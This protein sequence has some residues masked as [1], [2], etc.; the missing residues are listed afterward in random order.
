MNSQELKEKL[1]ISQ[2]VLRLSQGALTAAVRDFLNTYYEGQPLVIT[3][4]QPG[5]EGEP[6]GTIQLTGRSSF[7]NVPD[8]PVSARFSVDEQGEVHALLKYRLR[9]EAP[10]PAA[11]TFSRSFPKLPPVIDYDTE[12]PRGSALG[13]FRLSDNQ[14][15]FLDALDLFDTYFVV[16]TH[17]GKDPELGVPLEVGLNFVSRL[18]PQGM[19]GV[20]EHTLGEAPSLLLYG[21]IR[22]PKATDITLPL[23]PMQLPWDQ[24]TAPGIHLQAA[25]DAD[26]ELGGLRFNRAC[27]RVYSPPSLEWMAANPSFEPVHGYAGTLAIPSAG[28]E[29]Q[30]GARLQWNLPQALL[31]A[32]CKGITLGKMAHLLDLAGTGDLTAYLPEE[33]RKPI[34]ALGSLELMY[35][36]V[37]LGLSGLTPVLDTAYFTVGF[38]RLKWKVWGDHLEVE[39][40][41]CHFVIPSPLAASTTPTSQPAVSVTMFGTLEVEG[42][43]LAIRASNDRGF[44]VSAATK[45]KVSL[46]LDKL[47]AAYAPGVPTP[48]ALTINQLG[49]NV[50]LGKS[51]SMSA[52]LAGEPEPWTIPLGPEKLEIADVTLNFSYPTGGPLAGSFG[53]KITFAEGI[54]LRA[55]YGIP[56]NFAVEGHFPRVKLSNLIEKLC[57]QKVDLPGGFDLVLDDSAVLIQKQG[58]SYIFRLC[59]GVKDFGVFAFEVRKVSGGKWGY[60]AGMDLSGGRLSQLPGL[61]GLRVIEDAFTLQK[62]MLVVSS[63][64]DASF[65]FPTLAQFNRPQLATKNL[66]LPAQTSGVSPGLMLFAEWRLDTGD[67]QQNLLSKLLGLGITQSVTLAV[68]PD[69]MKSSRLYVSQRATI[70][71]HPFSCTF[72]VELQSG[73]PN[74]FLTG[75]LTCRIQGQPQTFD[76]TMAFAPGGAF[77]SG[78]MKGATAINCGPFKLSNLA[79]EVGV[80]WA[81]IPSLGVAATIDVKKFQSSVAVFFDSTDPS[82]SLVAGSLS[83][84]TLE[85]VVDSLVGGAAPSPLDEILG[86][87]AV[88][89]TREFSIPGDLADELDG[90]AFDKVSS[91][92]STAAKIQIPSSASQLLL[93]VNK[94]GSAWHL[95]DLTTMRHYQLEKRGDTIAV[96]IAPQ[97]YFAPQATSIGSLRYPQGFY[98]N[99][100]IAFLGFKAEAT[101]DISTSKGASIDAQMDRIA[102]GNEKLFCISAEQGPG[103][104]RIS[105]STFTQPDHPVKEFRPPHF[106]VNGSLVLLGIKRSVY[107]SLSSKG[108]VFDLQGP[109]VPGVNFNVQARLGGDGL[110]ASGEIKVGVGTLDLGKLGKVRLQTELK[111]KLELEISAKE[112]VIAAEASFEFTGQQVHIG[113]FKLDAKPDVLKELPEQLAR[114]AEKELTALFSDMGKWASAVQ[115]GLV[116]GVQDTAKVFEDVYG[117]GAKEAS[118]EVS[119]GAKKAGKEVSKGAKKAGK[120]L[121]KLF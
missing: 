100:A 101:I 14:R 75:S 56:G 109:L 112:I 87:I 27:F 77:F 43:P 51:Y 50:S 4:A 71:G 98:L 60:A 46:P 15:P 82:R 116:D 11:W 23:L 119:K 57:D 26:L 103:G 39:E 28:I 66:A 25:L 49:V 32:E 44:T 45:G 9:E 7:L 97:F 13:N 18:R 99:A 31:F 88:K 36:G 65:Q 67:R 52:I 2:G 20:L 79:L 33:L 94:K 53:G 104:P 120:K 8:L 63:F 58:D 24:P 55:R 22:L 17:A 95:T 38:P 78:T 74:L 84:L 61:S 92:F 3:D 110:D 89:G 29:L 107:A 72:G 118:K 80:N 111:G 106:Y 85:D 117:K 105:A 93:V 64:Q 21:T 91:A 83:D 62:L 113:R 5:P 37:E 73:K 42:V 1:A 6:A 70:Q 16:S 41:S 19:L 86:G 10:G 76:V 81:G 34:E 59:C 47:L 54:Q 68:S 69:P 96:S 115:D 102:L 35:V 108:L 90:L 40:L 114:R 30:L 48:S 12:L 121:K